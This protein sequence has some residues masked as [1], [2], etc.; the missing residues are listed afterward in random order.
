MELVN[1]LPLAKYCDEVRLGIRERLQLFANVCQAVQHAH[2]KGIVHRDLKPSNILVTIIDGEPVPKVIDFGVAKALSGKLTEATM[3]T[4]FGAVLG[5]LEYMAPEQAGFSGDDVDTRADI[6]SLG[7]VLYELLTGLKPLSRQ[8]LRDAAFDEAV[9]MVREDEPTKPSTQITT[10]DACSALA[11]LR[12]TAPE[13]L[14]QLL[15]GELDWIVMKCLEKQRARRYE[16]ANALLRDI[17]RY[18]ADEMVEARPPSAMYRLQK[19]LRRNK[20]PVV[21]VS[22]ILLALISGVIGT[23]LGLFEARRHEGL[24][25]SAQKRETERADS[26]ATLARKNSELANSERDARTLAQD[27]Q[28]IAEG[29]AAKLKAALAKSYFDEGVSK[30]DDGRIDT[31]LTQLMRAV[32]MTPT[33]NPLHG[34]YRRILVDRCLQGG[35]QLAPP[36]WH[37]AS[38]QIAAFSPNGKLVVTGSADRTARVWNVN[39]GNPVGALL[40]H[41]HEVICAAFSPDGA[42]LVTGSGENFNEADGKFA[43]QIWDVRTGLPLGQPMMHQKRVSCVAFNPNGTLLL[44]AETSFRAADG[45]C[46][47]QLWDAS[48]GVPAGTPMQHSDSI[49]VA[50]F[51]ADGT[52]VVTASHDMTARLWDARTGAPIGAMMQHPGPV[53][54]AAFGPDGNRV[55]TAS[56]LQHNLINRVGLGAFAARL[57]DGHSGS[58]IGKPLG[59][60]GPVT[61]VAFS[62]DGRRVAT[63]S[64]GVYDDDFNNVARL[65]DVESGEAVGTPMRHDD[66]VTRVAFS[67][68]GMRLLTLS[69]DKVRTWDA[70][71]GD[72]RGEPLR[73]EGGVT[74]AAFSPDGTRIVSSSTDGTARLWD[75]FE[76]GPLAEANDFMWI[77][78]LGF[79]PDGNRVITCGNNPAAQVWDA[80]SMTPI[81]QPMIHEH[82]DVFCAAFSPDGNRVATGSG[83]G[84]VRIWNAH[85]GAPLSEP[86]KQHTGLV[87]SIA[88]S[89][90]GEFLVTGSYDYTARLWDSRSGAPVGKIMQHAH[91][92]NS[93]AFSPDGKRVVTGSN[94]S[95]A[96]L[97]DVRTG[98]AVGVPMQHVRN[99]QSVAF[100]PDGERVATAGADNT[101]RLWSTFAGAPVGEV[102]KHE[103]EVIFVAFNHDGTRLVTTSRDKTARLWNGKTGAPIGVMRHGRSVEHATFSP[104]G[105]R[106]VT[107]SL[108][109]TAKFWDGYLG[110]AVG[111]VMTTV[112]VVNRVAF[113]PDGK[114]VATASPQDAV[115]IWDV[116]P[117][118]AEMLSTAS[119][120]PLLGLW[121]GVQAEPDGTFHK[122]TA[123]QLNR[124]REQT[125]GNDPLARELNERWRRRV[126]MR[127]R[128]NPADSEISGH[129]FSAVIHLEKLLQTDP[130]NQEI[131]ARL[132]FAKAKLAEAGGDEAAAIKGIDEAIRLDASNAMFYWSRGDIRSRDKENRDAA[133][134]DYTTAMRLK[135]QNP[136]GLNLQAWPRATSLDER[137]RNG[138][139]AVVTALQACQLSD[140]KSSGLI[141][142]LAAAYA[143]DGDFDNAVKWQRRAQELAPEAWKVEFSMRLKLYEAGKPYREGQPK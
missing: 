26:E 15:S 1:G 129:W 11:S 93:V 110:I 51:S 101:A 33:D 59:H 106:I 27:Q 141:D 42:R 108:D 43:A 5:T 22:L 89:P 57:W 87:L 140:W 69:N 133:V 38:V 16:T 124:I 32:A 77:S 132:K 36:L 14:R 31:G 116:T 12:Q 66:Q 25:M 24:A 88:F 80:H 120:A 79:S 107:T 34:S 115:R 44:T 111:G 73:H 61:S 68:D 46:V 119:L 90:N 139:R 136:R 94:D 70:Y 137:S 58:P 19:T 121:T 103:R 85:T 23:T 21:A 76:P 138:L 134:A 4:N 49:C 130:E 74:S 47:A 50:A 60:L 83:D 122:L 65:W 52:R 45:G 20:G 97:W 3:C 104:D 78:F 53:T 81:G 105:L 7:V 10:T 84:A 8:R 102:M 82:P 125:A 71:T 6:Y 63:A 114:R 112:A 99:V 29:E 135:P 30:Y 62:P 56:G 131:Q 41:K 40:K 128:R 92:V 100:S 48:T 75:A 67:P 98:A 117:L 35:R 18:L 91:N 2:Q 17:Q 86:L 143:E 126:E 64:G 28:K 55:V 37:A 72:P 39:T 96:R 113:S 142:T 118:D 54:C 13:Q 109:R 123:E 95:T 9:R 127:N